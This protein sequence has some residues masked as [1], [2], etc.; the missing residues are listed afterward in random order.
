MID[1]VP[2]LIRNDYPGTECGS[3]RIIYS[4]KRSTIIVKVTGMPPNLVLSYDMIRSRAISKEGLYLEDS[5][6]SIELKVDHS[7]LIK[8][9]LP[10]PL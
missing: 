5:K 2:L 6:K 1:T 3:K 7:R 8:V 9:E 10:N 4:K